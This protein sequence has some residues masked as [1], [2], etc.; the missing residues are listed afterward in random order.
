MENG[1]DIDRKEETLFEQCYNRDEFSQNTEDIGKKVH[2]PSQRKK[3]DIQ[4][5]LNEMIHSCPPHCEPIHG[6]WIQD[7]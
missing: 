5:V 4:M 7:L 6:E 2:Q 1:S 3:L